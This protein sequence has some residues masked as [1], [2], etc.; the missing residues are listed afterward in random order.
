MKR[1]IEPK[2]LVE[3]RVPVRDLATVVSYLAKEGVPPRSRSE[4]IASAVSLLANIIRSNVP[5]EEP[6]LDE[7]ITIIDS[8]L[9]RQMSFER[10]RYKELQMQRF[11]ESS[12]SEDIDRKMT[13]E[14]VRESLDAQVRMGLITPEEA[15][16]Y[17][18]NF[19][20]ARGM[21]SRL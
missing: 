3:S 18:K 10:I 1:T 12:Q 7:A 20:T 14:D 4:A 6:S 2:I 16:E 19:L 11:F 13:A 21:E 9:G 8:M 15:E 5:M 17:F